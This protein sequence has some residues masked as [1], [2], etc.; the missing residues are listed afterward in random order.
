MNQILSETFVF[1]AITQLSTLVFWSNVEKA[2]YTITNYVVSESSSPLQDKFVGFIMATLSL[3]LLSKVASTNQYIILRN[4]YD[5]WKAGL[6][7]CEEISETPRF[8]YE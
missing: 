3:L 5:V 1:M 2:V 7:E 8:L 4:M 6:S